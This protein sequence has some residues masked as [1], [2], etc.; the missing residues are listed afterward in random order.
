M[1]PADQN[2]CQRCKNTFTCRADYIEQCQCTGVVLSDATRRFLSAS[3]FKCLCV[4]CLKELN[5]KFEL[6]ADKQ[7]PK[8]GK[9]PLVE[10]FHYYKEGT[11]WVFTEQYLMLRGYC[12]NNQCR[13]CPYGFH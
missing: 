1:Q 10:G 3:N 2:I 5:Q 13:H 4:N 7:F 11:R 9:D 6:L 8:R 12:C